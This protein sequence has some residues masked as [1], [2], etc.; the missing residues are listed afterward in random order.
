MKNSKMT[1]C[2]KKLGS[3]K[4]KLGKFQDLIY[5]IDNGDKFVKSPSG[6][7]CT[8]IQNLIYLGILDKNNKKEYFITKLGKKNILTPYAKN[9]E[10]YKNRVNSLEKRN[11]ELFYGRAEKRIIHITKSNEYYFSKWENLQ[12]QLSKILIN[13]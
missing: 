10:F 6:Y 9:I 3:K 12:N 5:N 11:N 1:K 2:L 13:Q 7:Y 4:L 8:N